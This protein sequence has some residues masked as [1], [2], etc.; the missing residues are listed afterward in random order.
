VQ[1]I[2]TA[3]DRSSR[4]GYTAIAVFFV[5]LLGFFGLL[6]SQGSGLY[7]PGPGGPKLIVWPANVTLMNSCP[8][9]GVAPCWNVTLSAV[10]QTTVPSTIVQFLINQTSCDYLNCTFRPYVPSLTWP[11]RY[12]T[13][14]SAGAL[15]T[16][17]SN[18]SIIVKPNLAVTIQ[19]YLDSNGYSIGGQALASGQDV[20][21]HMP[22]AEGDIWACQFVLP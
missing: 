6:A 11:V 2:I 9:G 18:L 3:Q 16:T 12:T 19:F 8:Q 7:V 20:Y 17:P 5:G 10:D 21:I 14:E 22:G 4:T 13:N 15:Y 1:E